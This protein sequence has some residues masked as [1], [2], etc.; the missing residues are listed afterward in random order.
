MGS[1]SKLDAFRPYLN[2]YG[3][4]ITKN[5][6]AV[7]QIESA[8]RSLTYIVPARFKDVELASE[9][10]HSG[11]QLL[12]LYHDSVLARAGAHLP[13]PGPKPS[14]HSRYTK[15][16]TQK[17]P[18]YKRLALIVTMIQ[19]TELLWEMSAKRRGQKMRWRTVIILETAKAVCR[20]LLLRLTNSRPLLTPPLPEREV[21]PAALEEQLDPESPPPETTWRMPRTGL[22]LPSLPASGQVSQYL[23]TKVLTAEDVKPPNQLLHRVQ[24][25]GYFAEVLYIIRPVVYAIAMKQWAHDKKSWRPWLVGVSLEYAARQLAK[26]DFELTVP[27]GMKGLTALEREELTRRAW[28]MGWWAMRGAFY[29]NVSGPWL[30][31]IT[32]KLA[33]KPVL[34]L[35]AGLVDDYQYLWDNYYFSTAT[36]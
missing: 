14:P 15:F 36:L 4:F 10:I 26:R 1:V 3:D 11:I 29:E 5:A 13:A 9:S 33:D 28:S 25:T 19:Y 21:D 18:G 31:T 30:K 20:L 12:S 6:G 24:G 23:L 16:W 8:L 22:S 2:M 27:G 7:S 35:V 17:S 32:S 34:N